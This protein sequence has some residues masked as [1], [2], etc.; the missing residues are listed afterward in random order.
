MRNIWVVFSAIL[1]FFIV[2]KLFDTYVS[3]KYEVDEVKAM[4]KISDALIDKEKYLKQIIFWLWTIGIYIITSF[5]IV[6]RYI[7][8]KID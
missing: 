3:L 8:K 5:I 1:I 2:L 4:G 6:L 7:L